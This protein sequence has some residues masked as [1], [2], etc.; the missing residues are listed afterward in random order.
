[1]ASIDP[2]YDNEKLNKFINH[3]KLEDLLSNSIP[4][5]HMKDITGASL[6]HFAHCQRG[7]LLDFLED[8]Y[9]KCD[10]GSGDL[11]TPRLALPNKCFDILSTWNNSQHKPHYKPNFNHHISAKKDFSNLLDLKVKKFCDSYYEPFLEEA[12]SLFFQECD[13]F[14]VPASQRVAVIHVFF[15]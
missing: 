5:Q 8:N 14:E 2:E 1:M 12:K 15:T 10:R 13:G 7:V 3:A 11:L 4:T 9:V 6:T